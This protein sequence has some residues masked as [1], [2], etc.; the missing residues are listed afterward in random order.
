MAQMQTHAFLSFTRLLIPF[1]LKTAFTFTIKPNCK[2]VYPPL[3]HA[4]ES[5]RVIICLKFP[6]QTAIQWGAAPQND[7]QFPCLPSDICTTLPLGP[8]RARLN[9]FFLISFPL[10]VAFGAALPFASLLLLLSARWCWGKSNLANKVG[11]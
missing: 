3:M 10:R 8:E 9:F 7:K 11:G 6:V 2:N 4:S 5:L 1:V